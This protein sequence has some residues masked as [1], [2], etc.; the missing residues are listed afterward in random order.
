[1]AD[2]FFDSLNQSITNVV[3]L[4]MKK[5]EIDTANQKWQQQMD[6]S[7][8]TRAIAMGSTLLGQGAVNEG[9]AFLKSGGVD[10]D[11]SVITGT[12][13]YQA[14]QG[15]FQNRL[16]GQTAAEKLRTLIGGLP[17][18]KNKSE[19][20]KRLTEEYTAKWDP[21]SFYKRETTSEDL[22]SRLQ[23]ALI[24]AGLKGT[25]ANEKEQSKQL[26]VASE[27][28]I[29][30]ILSDTYQA[31]PKIGPTLSKK[32]KLMRIQDSQATVFDALEPHQRQAFLT[33]VEGSGRRLQ[34]K[35]AK[36][37][38]QAVRE[39]LE[40]FNLAGRSGSKTSGKGGSIWR[41]YLRPKGR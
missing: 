22:L 17:E 19:N 4:A 21:I 13:D 16:A 25:Q 32:L 14:K 26:S 5:W 41:Q 20:I 15:E 24:V 39:E 11:P 1:M 9:V 18:D 12:L 34:G 6:E 38:S 33:I 37:A 36:S 40:S 29:G 27:K 3:P 2:P 23:N 7:R 31:D 10:I 35:T 30:N 8:K 28:E